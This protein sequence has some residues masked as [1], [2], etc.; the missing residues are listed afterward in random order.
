MRRGG[1]RQR[2]QPDRLTCET[3]AMPLDVRHLAARRCRSA[4]ELVQNGI[5]LRLCHRIEGAG[6]CP[7]M[8]GCDD[9]PALQDLLV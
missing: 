3:V 7:H 5:N 1:A 4:V 9:A 6:R 2:K 8:G